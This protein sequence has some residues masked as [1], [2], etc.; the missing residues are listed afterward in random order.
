MQD[1]IDSY[2]VEERPAEDV[3]AVR[4]RVRNLTQGGASHRGDDA[5][6]AREQSPLSEQQNYHGLGASLR[7]LKKLSGIGEI[8]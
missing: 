6:T 3:E 4:D 2:R 1:I 7:E 8:N 5:G